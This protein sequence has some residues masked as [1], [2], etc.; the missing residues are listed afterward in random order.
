MFHFG[1]I[2]ILADALLCKPSINY[3]DVAGEAH[4]GDPVGEIP[5]R[6]RRSAEG[7]EDAS[8]SITNSGKASAGS[9]LL[10]FSAHP[11]D[12]RKSYRPHDDRKDQEEMGLFRISW[13]GHGLKWRIRTG[14]LLQIVHVRISTDYTTA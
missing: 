2:V 12:Q 4:I 8:C 5:K 14:V 3:I 1:S 11:Q 9:R 10:V 7:P 13:H 6:R